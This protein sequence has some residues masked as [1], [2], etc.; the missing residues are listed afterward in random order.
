MKYTYTVRLNG[1]DENPY[2]KWGLRANP[3]PQIGKA[4]W[5]VHERTL[6]MLAAEPIPDVEFLRQRLAGFSK[7]FVEL[8]CGQFRKGEIVTFDVSWSD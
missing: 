7:E 6:N 2:E 5:A 1:T 4:E 8:C 3:F